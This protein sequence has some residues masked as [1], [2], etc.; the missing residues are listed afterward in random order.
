MYVHMRSNMLKVSKI[1]VQRFIL[2]IH[3]VHSSEETPPA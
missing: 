2:D 3:T 1:D